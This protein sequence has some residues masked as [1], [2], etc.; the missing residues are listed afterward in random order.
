MKHRAVFLTI[1]GLG[2][3]GMFFRVLLTYL[4]IDDTV[5]TIVMVASMALMVI[6]LTGAVM[7]DDLND[8]IK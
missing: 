2:V 1:I 4:K 5:Q 7:Q 6:G 8:K 3:L